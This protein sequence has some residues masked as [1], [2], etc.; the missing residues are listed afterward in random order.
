MIKKMLSNPGRLLAY[1]GICTLLVLGVTSAGWLFILNKVEV[2]LTLP[3][4]E[5]VYELKDGTTLTGMARKL[6]DEGFIESHLWLRI[7]GR[8]TFSAGQIK[9]G[10]YLLTPQMTQRD[11]LQLVRAGKVIQRQFT[12]IEGWSLDRIRAEMASA[13]GLR[14][15]TAG[16]TSA[17]LVSRLGIEQPLAEGWFYPDTYAYTKGTTDLSLLGQSFRRMQTI[18]DR[19]WSNRQGNLPYQDPYEALVL[20]SVVEKETGME[21]DRDKIAAV[22]VRRW[23]RNIKLQ[24]D[25]TVIYGMGSRFQG[26]LRRSDLR[27][28]TPYNTYTNLGLPPT[29]ICS[30]GLGS[31]RA[32]LHPAEITSLYFVSRGDGSSQFSDT[33]EE[34]NRAVKQYQLDRKK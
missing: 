23:Q 19:E 8:L 34:H 32:A 18:L 22:F 4:T 1:A 24:S 3:T 5:F 29:P 7:Y 31:I 33:L 12:I 17:E 15:V 14:N 30:P 21:S 25:P 6:R 2:R 13:D 11:L 20:A 28:P 10:E 16:M 27:M 9:T 26:D